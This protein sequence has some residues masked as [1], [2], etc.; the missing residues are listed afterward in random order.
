MDYHGL[1]DSILQLPWKKTSM[2]PIQKTGLSYEKK[3]NCLFNRIHI[4][5]HR[6][7]SLCLLGTWKKLSRGVVAR[8]FRKRIWKFLVGLHLRLSQGV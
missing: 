6:K 5:C 2:C 3:A 8:A 4:F 1:I 7:H